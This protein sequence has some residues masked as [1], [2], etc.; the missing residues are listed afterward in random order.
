MNLHEISAELE[1]K[2]EFYDVDSMDVV[3]HGNYI[4]YFE[5]ARCAL[6]DKIGCG[7]KEMEKS[8]YAFP[9]TGISAKFVRPLHF[10]E[11][12]RARAV[13][14]E[15]ENRLRIK[16]ELFNAE[17]GVLTTKGV[18]TQMAYD[19]VKDDSLFVCPRIFTDRI[20]SLLARNGENLSL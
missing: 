2:V 10:G 14:D 8:G 9:V 15:Y 4:K 16:Y 19:I 12:I 13:L 3:W 17:T 6:L 5:K 1:F 11:R 20:E 18:S 7:Y